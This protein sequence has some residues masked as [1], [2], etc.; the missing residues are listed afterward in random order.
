MI[1]FWKSLQRKQNDYFNCLYSQMTNSS[2]CLCPLSCYVWVAWSHRVVVTWEQPYYRKAKLLWHWTIRLSQNL[3]DPFL[4][5]HTISFDNCYK[6]VPSAL[7]KLMLRLFDW[8]NSCRLWYAITRKYIQMYSF[9][10]QLRIWTPAL[11]RIQWM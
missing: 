11:K 7:S 1:Y 5:Y 6:I 8:H 3:F 2:S 9:L 4:Q 10:T